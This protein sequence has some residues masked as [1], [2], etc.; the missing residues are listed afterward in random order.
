M[1][2]AEA[3]VSP[4]VRDLPPSGI[5]RFFDLVTRSRG[6]ISLGVGEPDFPTPWRVRDA[7]LYAIERGHT[8][9]TSNRG[10]P[11][12][13]EATAAYLERW[14][15]ISYDPETEIMVTVG[16]AEGIDLALRATLCPG[17]EVLVPE[18]CFVSYMPCTTLAGGVPVPVPLQ[19][20]ADFRLQPAELEARLSQRSKALLMGYPQ[21]PTGAIM[22]RDDLLAVARV[23][24][25]ADL[26]V[27]SD[28]IYG[29]LT[30]GGRHASLAALPG[31]QRRTVLLGG[32]SKAHA[33]TGWRIGYA[34]GPA[35]IISAM[36]KIHQYSI[37][38]APAMGQ[39]AALEALR[40]GSADVARMAGEYD[41]RRRLMLTGCR[42]MGLPCF[43]P[44]GAFYIFP[45]IT[46]TGLTD[47]EFAL[48]LLEE[49]Q[50]AV[51]PGSAFGPSGR[52]H[53]RCSYAAAVPKLS[54]ALERI[55]RFVGRR[56]HRPA[57][58]SA[59]AVER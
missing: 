32:F 7:G 42:E 15:G 38:C 41:R 50:V 54:T 36:V 28:E 35:P 55:G 26:L 10:L 47:E 30:F 14:Q 43:E 9:Y 4:V 59:P 21:N 40:T 3:F 31:M 1:R 23:A 16:V 18:P 34:C 24:E 44:R 46:P 49:E 53:V 8:T 12:L 56:M 58:V 25:A 33:M 48:Q 57:G 45:D 37:M 2:P 6:I 51:V 17:D 5:R 52:G 20:A 11:E 29:E 27:I 13:C 19:A 39:L 22:E